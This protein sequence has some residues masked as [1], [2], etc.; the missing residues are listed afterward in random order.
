M[1]KYDEDDAKVLNAEQWQLD[2]LKLNP[3]YVWWGNYEDYMSNEKGWRARYFA[4]SFDELWDLDNLN[5]VVNFYFEV[6]RE[7]HECPH[8]EGE[9][10]NPETRQLI[11]DWY[12]FEE[13]GRRWCS[14]L[15]E[16][17]VEAL[18]KAGRLSDLSDGWYKYDKE[19]DSWMKMEDEWVSCD[20]PKMPSPEEVNAW[21]EGR[22]LGHDAINRSIC[23]RARAKHLGVYGNCHHCEGL[24]YIYDSDKAKVSLQLWMLH[25]RKGCSK[26]VYIKEIK[27][28]DLPK[29]FEYLREADQRNQNRFKG[30][31]E[32]NK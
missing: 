10:V 11:E 15:T 19:K 26:G 13:T 6:T 12:D 22:G 4:E 20:K 1:R 32:V 2:L 25:P 5:E 16:V 27:Q 24:G 23:V 14:K 30:I 18:F 31:R 17:E 28:T 9:G 21:N 29:V 8:C 3:S 7:N